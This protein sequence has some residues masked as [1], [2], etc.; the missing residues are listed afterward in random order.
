[1]VGREDVPALLEL[2]AETLVVVDFAVKNQMQTARGTALRDRTAVGG[3]RRS[4]T[5][6]K[7]HRLMAR[8]INR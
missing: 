3:R 8:R 2:F 6:S 4:V 5:R 1:M 7:V